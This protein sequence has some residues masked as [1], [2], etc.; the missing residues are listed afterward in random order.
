MLGDIGSFERTRELSLSGTDEAFV[1]RW[2]CLSLMVIRSILED[3]RDVQD[4]ARQG[5]NWLAK[6]DSTG[7]NDALATAQRIDETFQKA[8][9]CLFRLYDVLSK[10]EDLTEEVKEILRGYN[11]NSQISE[12]EQINT[13]G[14]YLG[15]VDSVI[16][17][18]QN[19]IYSDRHQ[20]ISQFPGVLDDFSYSNYSF[21]RFVELSRDPPK[22]QFM[23]PGKTLRG[24]CTPART[25]RNVLNGQEDADAYKEL[26]KDLHNFCSQ[27][28]WRGDEMQRQVWC[29]QDLHDRGGLG[30]TVELFFLALSQLLSTSSS[31]ESHLA[32]YTCTFRAITTDWSRHKASL[33]TQNL[34]LDIAMSRRREFNEYYPTYIAD[35]FLL[36]LGNIFEGQ[37]GPHIDKARQQFESFGSAYDPRKFRERVLRILN[38]GQAQP[39]TS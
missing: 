26:L 28:R 11:L 34:L 32:L 2:T 14:G 13:E 29:L 39:P 6:E 30:F 3:N 1:M 31:T 5:V 18:M 4:L 7:N 16:S 23:C 8:R 21:S 35:E 24:M 27:S 12:L 38:R 37:T 17:D 9:D 15:L 25:L 36:L 19:T 22:L 33:G 20:I 10:T